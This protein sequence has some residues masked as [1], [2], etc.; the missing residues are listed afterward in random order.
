VHRRV[1]STPVV[2]TAALLLVATPL[3]GQDPDVAAAPPEGASVYPITEVDWKDDFCAGAD[4]WTFEVP[5]DHWIELPIGWTATDEAT[6]WANWKDMGYELSLEGR[7]LEVPDTTEWQ[8]MELAVQCGDRTIRAVAVS[9]L[10]YLPPVDT[11]RNYR[12]RRLFET[13]VNTGF[14]TFRKGSRLTEV[15]RFLPLN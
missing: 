7:V 15:L 2:I 3:S 14:A 12:V 10:V 4:V 8:V 13:D 6:G 5:R 9:P 11:E 1:L